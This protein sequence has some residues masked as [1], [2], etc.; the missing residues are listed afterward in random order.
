LKKAEQN[1]KVMERVAKIVPVKP[2]E[3]LSA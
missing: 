1:K 3:D 2:T